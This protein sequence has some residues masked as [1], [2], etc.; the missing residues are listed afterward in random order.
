MSVFRYVTHTCHR[1]LADRC[2]GDVF[3][4]HDNASAFQGFQTG[5]PIDQ[6]RL[7]V[8]VDS[9]NTDDF[10]FPHLEIHILNCVFFIL[11]LN[12]HVLYVQHDLSRLSR[13]LL[14]FKA[15]IS[16]HHH[17]G[18]LLRCG[19]LCL[20]SPH[21]FS[22]PEDGTS[23]GNFHDLVQLVGNKKDAFSLFCKSFHDLH[24]LFDFLY[25]QYCR[26]LVKN[27]DLIIPVQHF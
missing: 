22:F 11:S 9:C 3:P 13:L 26:R 24:Q 27:Q 2:I 1:P 15:Y 4:L 12:A 14:Y 19:V 20:N 23:V 6:F 10:T 17:S 5:Q 16:S 25:R 8:S 7:T 21:I 18:Q